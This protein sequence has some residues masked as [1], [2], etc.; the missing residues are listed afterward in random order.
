MKDSCGLLKLKKL[1]YV[2]DHTIYP[3]FMFVSHKLFFYLISDKI[4]TLFLILIFLLFFFLCYN[5]YLDVY[6]TH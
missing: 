6:F 3:D 4:I 2:F 5:I 1:K